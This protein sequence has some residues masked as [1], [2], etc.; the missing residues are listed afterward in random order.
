MHSKTRI[1]TPNSKHSQRLCICNTHALIN[2]QKLAHIHTHG[3]THAST[4]MYQQ[5]GKTT[6]LQHS[7]INTP[8][9]T[10]THSDACTN[11]HAPMHTH[12]HAHHNK[13]APTITHQK[14]RNNT[15]QHA[16]TTRTNHMHQRN[17]S[18]Q[19]AC[20]HQHVL[21]QQPAGTYTHSQTTNAP[22]HML[23]HVRINKHTLTCTQLHERKHKNQHAPKHIPISMH[24]HA[25]TN[26]HTPI[27]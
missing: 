24:Q 26:M 15:H 8:E 16:R 7:F 10:C 13:H 25:C 17:C 3:K 4:C 21:T 14:S 9:T 2:M 11:T 5:T 1:H 27:S 18:H 12:Q 19:H 6:T 22:T 20:I 23:Q